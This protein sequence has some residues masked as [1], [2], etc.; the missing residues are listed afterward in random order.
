MSSTNKTANYNLS[1]FIGTDKPAWLTDYNSDMSKID[2]GIDAAK[3]TADAASG[4]ASAAST[5]IGDLTALTTT[6]KTDLVNAI[7]EVDSDA[8][9]AQTSANNAY[10]LANTANTTVTGLQNYLTLS[11]ITN[12]NDVANY[13][14]TP[15]MTVDGPNITVAKNNTSSLGKI[16]GTIWGNVSADGDKV[17]TLNVDTGINPAADIVI[18][19]AGLAI[20]DSGNHPRPITMTIKTTGKIELSMS[21]NGTGRIRFFLNPSLYFF[22]DFGD[23]PTPA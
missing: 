11:S 18:Y 4:A 22:T 14:V 8:G 23:V 16:Y 9:T 21:I 20:F 10:N 7:N 13:T 1:Q 12:Y 17:I 5:S 3:D 2:A 6:A 15:G 19:N